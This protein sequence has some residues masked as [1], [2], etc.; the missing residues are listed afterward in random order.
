MSGR[1]R[2]CGKLAKF[3]LFPRSKTCFDHNFLSPPRCGGWVHGETEGRAF[4][5]AVMGLK[6]EVEKFSNYRATAG[7]SEHLSRSK[8]KASKR[9]VITALKRWTVYGT[10]TA[11]VRRLSMHHFCVS[12]VQRVIR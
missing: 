5:H 1:G 7:N 11:G 2:V 3:S 8:A 9:K 10:C 4:H 12:L 6:F